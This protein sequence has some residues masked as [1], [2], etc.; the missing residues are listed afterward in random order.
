MLLG[1][2][3]SM[4]KNL[5]N[6]MLLFFVFS[7]ISSDGMSVF[8]SSEDE[9]EAWEYMNITYKPEND[10]R[11]QNLIGS[12]RYSEV[13][14]V[15]LPSGAPAA[16]KKLKP[17]DEKRLKREVYCLQL[18][19][20]SKNIIKFEGVYGDSLTPILVTEFVKQDPP[21]ITTY[22]ELKW[23]M[24][25]LLEALNHSHSL[26]IMHRDVK[27]Q[28]LV[29]SY[30]EKKFALIDWGLAEIFDPSYSYSINV[31][32]K[33]Y[34]APE[35][36]FLHQ[37]Y[38]PSIDAWAA[39][40]VMANLLFGTPAFFGAHDNEGVK[41]KQIRFFGSNR[42]KHIAKA[43]GYTKTLPFYQSQDF[44]EYALPHTR[45]LFTN[46]SLNLLTDLLNPNNT[47]RITPEKALES[48]FFE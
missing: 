27:L 13:F 35:L 47:Q 32:T 8:Q 20:Q 7:S 3:L 38:T 24:F 39:G 44:L 48:C 30:I 33:S 18:V 12:G 25:S 23:L 1:F 41:N 28:N 10:L 17:I 5:D 9:I 2:K 34:K 14:R 43:Y 16:A 4:L 6:L 46:C 21:H 11:F 22:G 37:M 29:F 19:N 40:C 26:R 45:H 15:I 42:M 36:L 31:G